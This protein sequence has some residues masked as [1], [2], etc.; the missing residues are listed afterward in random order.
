[1]RIK[2]LKHFVFFEIRVQMVVTFKYKKRHFKISRVGT[3]KNTITVFFFSM[4]QGKK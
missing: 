1:M 3:L 2:M 4:I